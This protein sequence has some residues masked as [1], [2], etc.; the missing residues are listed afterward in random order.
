M[1]NVILGLLCCLVA[2]GA[3]GQKKKGN[4]VAQEPVPVEYYKDGEAVYMEVEGKRLYILTEEMPAFPTG[5]VQRWVARRVT[6]PVMAMERG[7]SGT[8]YV[9]FVVETD[10]RVTGVKAK[11]DADA[12]LRRE[13]ERVFM[14]S[15]AW[16]PGKHNGEAVRVQMTEPIRFLLS[17]GMEGSAGGSVYE[18]MVYAVTEVEPRF[19]EGD[20]EEWIRMQV[21]EAYAGFPTKRRGVTGRAFV[22]FV[23]EKNGALSDVKA[24][25]ATDEF[26]RKAAVR[27][28]KSMPKWEP[29]KNKGMPAR[30]SMTLQV[31]FQVPDAMTPK[32]GL[33]LKP[34]PNLSVTLGLSIDL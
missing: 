34:Y 26:L 15:P 9:Q 25:Y 16:T 27:I 2:T 18:D 6:Y 12:L 19:P 24:I 4:T 3:A 30:H 13:A 14:Q 32:E 29:G 7:I 23:I 28:I 17:D 5:D 22:S 1:K 21:R 8:V 11:E 31:D 10:G 20:V 33:H